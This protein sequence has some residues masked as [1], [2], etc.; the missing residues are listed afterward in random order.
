MRRPHPELLRFTE[1]VLAHEAARTP[2]D[3]STAIERACE[4]LRAQLD[5]VIGLRGFHALLGRAIFL[6]RTEHPWLS[7]LR[8]ASDDGCALQVMA[9]A[10]QAAG[11]DADAGFISILATTIALLASFIGEDLTTRFLRETWPDVPFE[12]NLLPEGSMYE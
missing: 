5:R 8:I 7:L 3:H 2:L 9:E 4:A 6:R 12:N 10:I 11:D 1:R